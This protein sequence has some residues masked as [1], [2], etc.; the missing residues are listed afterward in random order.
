[1]WRVSAPCSA[2]RGTAEEVPLGYDGSNSAAY[3]ALLPSQPCPEPSVLSGWS[4]TVE[5]AP[6]RVFER[7][8]QTEVFVVAY[9]FIAYGVIFGLIGLYLVTLMTR[10]K[11]LERDIRIIKR[12]LDRTHK[13]A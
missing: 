7:S 11:N 1:M 9:L 10:Q 5:D 12:V 3:T 8:P 2:R 13:N 6:V 4:W